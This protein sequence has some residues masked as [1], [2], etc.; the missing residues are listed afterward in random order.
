MDPLDVDGWTSPQQLVRIDQ[1]IRSVDI[2]RPVV[3]IGCH[4]GRSSIAMGRAAAESG[5]LLICI[6]PW[7]DWYKAGIE[8]ENNRVDGEQTYQQYQENMRESGLRLG[9]DYIF[10][11][12]S[13]LEASEIVS[14]ASFVFVDGS[15]TYEDVLADLRAWTPKLDSGSVIA[16]DDYGHRRFPGVKQA[17][18]EFFGSDIGVEKDLVLAIID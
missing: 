14:R 9:A 13:S 12:M 17:W 4:L 1:L 2:G 6:D 16:G 15:H 5:R 7:V 10:L 3:E 11:R 18:D 8:R